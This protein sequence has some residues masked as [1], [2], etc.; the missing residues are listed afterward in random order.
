MGQVL[1]ARPVI[2]AA[3]NIQVHGRA[4]LN[5][6]YQLLV[7]GVAQNLAAAQLFFEIAGVYRAQ[8]ATVAGDATTLSIVVE[9][10]AIAGLPLR[11]PTPFAL[12]DSTADPAITRWDGFIVVRGYEG[13]PAA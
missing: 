6:T 10:T 12:V 4:G 9:N 1:N 7:A 2:D 8:L 5:F 3:G 13:Q 11:T